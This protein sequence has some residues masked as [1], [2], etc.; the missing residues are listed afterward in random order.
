[1]EQD[2]SEDIE[3]WRQ[4]L[5]EKGVWSNKP[6]PLFPYPGSP[7]YTTRWGKRD[8]VAWERAHDL[9]ERD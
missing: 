9:S 3:K 5:L 6:V 4:Q 2:S 7:E 1:M 8:D